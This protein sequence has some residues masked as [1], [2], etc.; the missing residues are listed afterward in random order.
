MPLRQK[1]SG[2]GL[3]VRTEGA[4]DRADGRRSRLPGAM[5]L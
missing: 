1:P 3:V 4:G 5:T 2:A